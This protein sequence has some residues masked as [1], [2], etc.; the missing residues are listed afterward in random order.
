MGVGGISVLHMSTGA[1]FAWG[2]ARVAHNPKPPPLTVG[3]WRGMHN[4]SA[5]ATPRLADKGGG[6]A[7]PSADAHLLCCGLQVG[8]LLARRC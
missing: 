1:G 7:L 5:L 3:W 8:V 2:G 6:D 4:S